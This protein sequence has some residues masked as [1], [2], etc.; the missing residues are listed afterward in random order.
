MMRFH[1]L[2]RCTP[3]SADP[4]AQKKEV[5]QPIT[6]R[7]RCAFFVL[8][9]FVGPCLRAVR[10]A[11]VRARKQVR[12]SARAAALA[13]VYSDPLLVR[14]REMIRDFSAKRSMLRE[15]IARSASLRLRYTP[16]NTT[17]PSVSR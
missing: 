8:A 14:A 1:A 6:N 15:A 9:H 2:N 16:T 17:K 3:V 5:N 4:P 10:M 12:L 7:T 13:E 11:T